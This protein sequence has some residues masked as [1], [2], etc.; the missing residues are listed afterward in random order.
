MPVFIGFAVVV[1]VVGEPELAPSVFE[2]LSILLGKIE[3]ATISR[4]AREVE[5]DQLQGV[6]KVTPAK[7][8]RLHD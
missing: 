3:I 1:V 7:R 4:R 2:F 8:S 6:E 5:K